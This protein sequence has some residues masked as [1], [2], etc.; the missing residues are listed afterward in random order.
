MS[1]SF[2]LA[3]GV[4]KMMNN[5]NDGFSS[6]GWEPHNKATLERERDGECLTNWGYAFVCV[7]YLRDFQM[8]N[9]FPRVTLWG[10]DMTDVKASV[11][12]NPPNE[13]TTPGGQTL[14]EGK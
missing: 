1:M 2:Q 14:A 12:T 4:P 13:L 9:K 5:H 8:I 10:V 7:G 6:N 3:Y 11:T